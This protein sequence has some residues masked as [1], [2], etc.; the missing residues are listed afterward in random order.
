LLTKLL[1][2]TG[3][4]LPLLALF[5][6]LVPATF[7]A[8]DTIRRIIPDSLI[9]VISSADTAATDTARAD[10]VAKKKKRPALDSRVDYSAKDSLRLEIKDQKVVL[11]K[12]ANLKYQDIELKGDYVEIDF[13][14]HAVYATG[15]PDSTG[16]EAGYPEFK[17][18]D[19]TFKSKVIT[20]NYTTKKGYIKDVFTKQDE[21][22]LHGTVIKKMENNIT[23]IKSGS[24]TT[25]ENEEHPHFDF[26]FNKAKVIPGKSIITGPAYLEIAEV[27]TPLF[28]P[29]GYFPVRKGARS[30]ILLPT[31][32]ESA[33]QGFF[34]QNGGYYWAIN[35]H[36][37][38]KL[39]ADI[40]SHGSYAIKPAFTYNVRYKYSGSV[41]FSYAYNR[42]GVQGTPGFTTDKNF[43]FMWDHKQDKKA[44]PK[45]N[46]SASVNIV[47]ANYNKYN[48][49]VNTTAYLSNTFQSSINYFTSFG[50]KTTLN[51]NSSFME[52]TLDKSITLSLPQIAFTVSQIYPF[53]SQHKVGKAKWY[54]KIGIRYNLDAQ[55]Q[56]DAVDSTFFKPG[57]ST[58]MRNG[59][60]HT[61]P[62]GGSWQVLKYFNLSA[63]VS[64]T[65][66]MYFSYISER[67]SPLTVIGED[68]LQPKIIIDTLY[69]FRNAFDFSMSAGIN[70]R[71][72]AIYQ[73]RRGSPLMAIRHMM[74][75]TVG[76]TYT[77]DFGAPFWGYYHEIANLPDSLNL[78]KYS[79][80]KGA[81]YSSPPGVKSGLVSMSLANNLE[82]KVRNRK[83]TV[84]GMKKVMLIDN[85]SLATSYDVSKDTMNWAPL[86]IQARTTLFK[87]LN[88]Q[89]Y[90]LWDM[91]ARDTSG[92]RISTTEWKQNNR[93][94]RLDITRWDVGFNYTLTSDK[95][96]KKQAPKNANPQEVQDIID[97]Y[98]N[99]VDFDIPW[100]FT[101]NYVFH[102]AKEY[103]I[104]KQARVLNLSQTL[105][106]NGQLNLTPKWKVTLYTG[107]DFTHHELSYTRIDIYRDLHCWEMRFGWIP[108]G[109]QQSWNFSI[110]VKASILQDMKL[111]K[112]KDFLDQ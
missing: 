15:L 47:S 48:P 34:L 45:S 51:I 17:Q 25:C 66:R 87:V 53:R 79:A 56:Y 93:F 32:G 86:V 52:N 23:Y 9:R 60:K 8:Q 14:K 89:Y 59:I 84:T 31:Y 26:R 5:L 44:R 82:A 109:P 111:N 85:L 69:G 54:D 96:K 104:S 100:S 13:P 97:Y 40:Y 22:Y 55:N 68:T 74:T 42:L 67:Y 63:A 39:I 102:I 88:L 110:N 107:W 6:V 49:A 101:V 2:N 38:L 1:T 57:W 78:P 35:K 20:Y 43:R 28:I 4:L 41:N 99:Y 98:D 30:G 103:N 12:E 36:M 77:P 106:F 95:V 24:Y 46:F 21:G 105:T 33:S 91:Y 70:T 64:T 19:Q 11:Y 92:R 7:R 90:S 94:L 16:K 29:F 37:D 76:F 112:K 73:F 61:V 75:P 50:S 58:M 65:D 71:I 27:P 18:G 83:D 80:F 10:T 62:I 3:G 108:K 72:Y 81:L